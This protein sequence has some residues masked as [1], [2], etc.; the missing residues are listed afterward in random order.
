M[1]KANTI[2]RCLFL[3]PSLRCESIHQ[4]LNE[5]VNSELIDTVAGKC[6]RFPVC[7]E[8]KELQE[9]RETTPKRH[10]RRVTAEETKTGDLKQKKSIQSQQIK[11]ISRRSQFRIDRKV[12][13][14]TQMNRWSNAIKMRFRNWRQRQDQNAMQPS[15]RWR[16]L[17]MVTIF[18]L[19]LLNVISFVA[20][21]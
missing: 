6:L 21:I 12:L 11:S 7:S 5:E 8:T 20:L 13:S 14:A 1:W 19:I 17:Q 2:E 3:V 9:N 15:W 16:V 18:L 4:R 10:S